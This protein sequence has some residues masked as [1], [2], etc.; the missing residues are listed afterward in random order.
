MGG[1]LTVTSTPG[2]GSIFQFSAVLPIGPKEQ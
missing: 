2:R 1:N